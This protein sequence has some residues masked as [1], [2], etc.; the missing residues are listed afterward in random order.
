M[1]H[2]YVALEGT[3]IWIAVEGAI[4]DLVK[5]SDLVESTARE[6]VVGYLCQKIVADRKSVLEQLKQS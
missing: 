6:Y 1:A 5:N 2:P 4:D 3:P